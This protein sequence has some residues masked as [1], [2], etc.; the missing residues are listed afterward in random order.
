[1]LGRYLDEGKVFLRTS[2]LYLHSQRRVGLSL[3]PWK[4]AFQVCCG[5]RQRVLESGGLIP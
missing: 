4:T 1:M 2:A 3:I 5:V